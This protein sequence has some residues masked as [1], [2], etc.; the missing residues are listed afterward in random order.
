MIG[1]NKITM[2]LLKITIKIKVKLNMLTIIKEIK[3]KIINKV[4]VK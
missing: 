1:I 4:V 2:I 3:G